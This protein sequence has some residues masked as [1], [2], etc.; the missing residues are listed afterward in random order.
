M[1]K[2]I[3]AL[4]GNVEEK[5]DPYMKSIYDNISFLFNKNVSDGNDPVRDLKDYE[6]L[7][8]EPLSFIRGRSISNAFFIIDEAQNTTP[9]EIKTIITRAGENTKIILTG[10]LEQIDAPY[11]SSNDCGL[12]YASESFKKIN[13]PIAA[14]IYLNQCERSELATEALKCMI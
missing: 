14:T 13:S 4:P 9:H 12:I 3:G 8:I 6:L 1:G 7:E 5:I 11:I 10:D 2:D